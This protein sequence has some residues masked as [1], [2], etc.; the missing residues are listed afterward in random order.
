M[1]PGG[2]GR[3]EGGDIAG[4]DMSP[5]RSVIVTSSLPRLIIFSIVGRERSTRKWTFW[6]RKR[7]WWS[8]SGWCPEQRRST[9]WRGRRRKRKWNPRRSGEDESPGGNSKKMMLV[10]TDKVQEDMLMEKDM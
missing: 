5:K 8:A 2:G 10:V 9:H 3:M 6:R 4:A 1:S 7:R